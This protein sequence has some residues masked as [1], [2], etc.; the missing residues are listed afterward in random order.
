M[1]DVRQAEKYLQTYSLQDIFE[2]NE[3]TEEEVLVL[4]VERSIIEL[5]TPSPCD[6]YD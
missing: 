2:I 3:L 6:L 4:L 5:P 1:L